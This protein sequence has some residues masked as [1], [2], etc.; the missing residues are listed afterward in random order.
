M[1]SPS[2]RRLAAVL[3]AEAVTIGTGNN[4]RMEAWLGILSS[5]KSAFASQIEHAGGTVIGRSHTAILA[6]FATIVNAV[7]CA[8][9]FQ[10][11][12]TVRNRGLPEE[13]RVYFRMGL[14]VGE[15]IVGGEVL[16]GIG[17][18][19]AAD[20]GTATVPGG[21]T[22]SGQAYDLIA[23]LK[24][25]FEPAPAFSL[26]GGGQNLR[27]FCKAPAEAAAVPGD[28]AAPAETTVSDSDDVTVLDLSNHFTVGEEIPT[29]TETSP[30]MPSMDPPTSVPGDGA[31]EQTIT[32]IEELLQQAESDA[33]DT[34][35][36]H[37][38]H[39]YNEVQQLT[40]G[41][42]QLAPERQSFY[43][44]LVRQNTTALE[45]A[46]AFDGDAVVEIS[47]QPFVIRLA[48]E[49]DIGR[50]RKGTNDG[51]VVGCNTVSR[52][53]GQ[54]RISLSDEGCRI[55]DAGSKNGTYIDGRCLGEGEAYALPEDQD[56]VSIYLGGNREPAQPGPIKVTLR[57][58]RG[59]R[60]TLLLHLSP[61]EGLAP[62]DL[63][64]IWPSMAADCRLTYV[65]SSGPVL[66]G[67]GE[68]CAVRLTSERTDPLARIEHH[69]HYEIAPHGAQALKINHVDF[70]QPVVLSNHADVE[71]EG[72][73]FQ[74]HARHEE[75]S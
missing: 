65:F 22:I 30:P 46:F 17:V 39:G 23:G 53:G 18:Q 54:T 47:G 8:L 56:E 7:E 4:L 16:T 38:M 43:Q 29:V 35:Y 20:L 60:L 27:V 68:D 36:Y 66:I 33:K 59:E 62:A 6:E 10:H 50:P 64:Q 63:Q 34:N 28:G 58:V 41:L 49:M 48:D 5:Y 71:V 24:S 19:T 14:H 11:S 2:E 40:N 44:D 74:V 31:A 9:K 13:N 57:Q 12:V 21:I 37:A 25:E 32:R 52:L 70:A 51:V 72:L 75:P 55:I 1:S 3:A 26:P 42:G 45:N 15:I 73:Q 67:N 61:R 69:R